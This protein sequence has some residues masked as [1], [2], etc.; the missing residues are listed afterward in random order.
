MLRFLY[1]FPFR[2]SSFIYP[3]KLLNHKQLKIPSVSRVPSVISAFFVYDSLLWSYLP[4]LEKCTIHFP[5]KYHRGAPLEVKGESLYLLL[6]CVQMDL[7]MCV[8]SLCRQLQ[9]V[10]KRVLFLKKKVVCLCSFYFFFSNGRCLITINP[11]STRWCGWI[12]ACSH[13]PFEQLISG[14]PNKK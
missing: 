7:N 12:N 9:F 10:S 14:I 4:L 3:W 13:W 11:L 8:C 2:T 5:G 1:A 6:V